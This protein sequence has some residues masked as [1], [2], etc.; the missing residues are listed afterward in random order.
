VA[1]QKQ[2]RHGFGQTTPL[3]A[4][5][6][7]WKRI[8]AVSL[9]KSAIDRNYCT[10]EALQTDPLLAK[11]RETGEFRELLSAAKD[12][13]DRVVGGDNGMVH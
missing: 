4:T 2:L 10:Y 12:C 6:D 5:Q 11:F 3:F 1:R 7:A 9:I 13:Q 8:S